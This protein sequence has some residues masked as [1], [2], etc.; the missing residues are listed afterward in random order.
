MNQNAMKILHQVNGLRVLK[1]ITSLLEG[2]K[3]AE[4]LSI[5]EAVKFDLMLTEAC[6]RRPHN[7]ICD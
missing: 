1:E 5:L 6:K 3:I 4:A 2:M 7:D